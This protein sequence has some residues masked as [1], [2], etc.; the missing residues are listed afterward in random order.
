MPLG[1]FVVDSVTKNALSPK[2]SRERAPEAL[3]GRRCGLPVPP[4]HPYSC[5]VRRKEVVRAQLCCR[6]FA[7]ETES[8]AMPLSYTLLYPR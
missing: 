1:R 5:V 2:G 4:F 3:A 8:Q 6:D 7:E